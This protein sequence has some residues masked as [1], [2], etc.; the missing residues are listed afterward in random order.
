MHPVFGFQLPLGKLIAATWLAIFFHILFFNFL[1]ECLHRIISFLIRL[2]F[3]EFLINV[4]P[5][6]IW[7]TGFKKRGFPIMALCYV[8]V[9]PQ[10]RNQ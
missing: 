8:T 1:P 3:L 10:V 6:D 2:T 4:C 7:I 9:C 5:T